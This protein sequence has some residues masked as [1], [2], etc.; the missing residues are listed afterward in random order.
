MDYKV[1]SRTF[2]ELM[3]RISK[4]Q[5]MLFGAFLV[6]ASVLTSVVAANVTVNTNNRVEF[7]QGVYRVG[8]CDSFINITAERNS[9]NITQL[10][11]DGLDIQKCASVYM[12]IKLLGSGGSPINLYE[13]SDTAVNRVMLRF[14]GN[15]D[16]YAG[17]DFYNVIG[18]P[19]AESACSDPLQ[20]NCRTDN[21]VEFDYF[22]GRYR[23][24]FLNPMA[25]A[26][27]LPNFVIE[28]SSDPFGNLSECDISP[29]VTGEAGGTPLRLEQ[30]IIE[31]L[32]VQNC[33][34]K[35]VRIQVRDSNSNLLPLYD[36][37]MSVTRIQFYIDDDSDFLDRLKFYHGLGQ[38]VDNYQNCQPFNPLQPY[39][40]QDNS[41]KVTYFN[42][43]YRIT[44]FDP[45]AQFNLVST[46]RVDSA[47]SRLS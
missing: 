24:I 39:C 43:T 16:P 33:V 29:A 26:S 3:I 2:E 41:L 15:P 13:E 32:D 20:V 40:K 25:S 47:D 30:V 12:R 44:F 4:S 21:N 36:S 18:Q 6:F 28:T 46:Y 34:G 31:N 10:I 35:Y 11:I 14:N 9:T 37:T 42:G 19:I 22:E 7:G 38:R 27:T 17:V 1:Q 8:A 45:L 5:K 23:I